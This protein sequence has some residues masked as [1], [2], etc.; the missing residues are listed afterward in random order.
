MFIFWGDKISYI[1]K[2]IVS[3]EN[4]FIFNESKDKVKHKAIT[5]NS[6][7]IDKI[8]E[9]HKP[10]IDLISNHIND[11]YSFIGFDTYKSIKDKINTI[12][13]SD[14]ITNQDALK[15]ENEVYKEYYNFLI[16]YYSFRNDKKA[17]KRKKNDDF[18]RLEKQLICV[19]NRI[20]NNVN[21][22]NYF[23]NNNVNVK[24]VSAYRCG[25]KNCLFC[26]R[27]KLL[28]NTLNHNIQKIN[29]VDV[30]TKKLFITVSID[31]DYNDNDIEIK[32]LKFK[33]NLKSYFDSKDFKFFAMIEVANKLHCHII[34]FD[35]QFYS[36]DIIQTELRALFGY[37][38]IEKLKS[39]ENDVDNNKG[40][41]D[42][43]SKVFEYISKTYKSD[44]K[45]LDI[46]NFL[47]I[48]KNVFNTF[49]HLQNIDIEKVKTVFV[50][51]INE[52]NIL[53][54]FKELK[55]DFLNKFDV[56]DSKTALRFLL[57]NFISR[58]AF[59]TSKVFDN[60]NK[61]TIYLKD[62]NILQKSNY[63]N[64]FEFVKTKKEIDKIMTEFKEY[65]SK[66]AYS[67]W[68]NF[69]LSKLNY[70][71]NLSKTLN[72]IFNHS[73]VVKQENELNDFD[74]KIKVF[75]SWF[76]TSRFKRI[77]F[78]NIKI[79]EKKTKIIFNENDVKF[80]KTK[81]TK[82]K[83]ENISNEVIEF[84]KMNKLTISKN[85]KNDVGKVANI[86]YKNSILKKN[87][88]LKIEDFGKSEIVN[89]IEIIVDNKTRKSLNKYKSNHSENEYN[90]RFEVIK[91][92]TLKKIM[93]K[94]YAFYSNKKNKSK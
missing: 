23:K 26:K 53:N 42:Y 71:I 8:K 13:N 32:A 30:N 38:Y 63:N 65:K 15:L 56:V 76:V 78:T 22:V 55:K 83:I 34:F 27:S 75:S 12:K 80:V 89:L 87:N 58:Y 73:E 90:S 62:L 86:F 88:S 81:Q 64:L 11:L 51:E 70:Y 10:D 21:V 92:Q 79:I 29:N 48:D 7:L 82:K 6:Q 24:T 31:V 93:G 1:R 74:E 45:S 17:K 35:I 72:L 4:S 43:V 44:D 91:K 16:K 40:V 47:T 54:F 36:F 37:N 85:V 52:S 20:E 14:S 28:K 84:K 3:Y 59:L 33:Q 67:I 46:Q 5:K 57:K 61:N 19:S 69:F 9:L 66:V 2:S 94:I 39:S 18:Q 60:I 41:F 68:K 25:L 49:L 77:F 50:Q